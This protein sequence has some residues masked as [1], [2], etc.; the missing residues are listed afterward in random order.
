MWKFKD[1]QYKPILTA[2]KIFD[3][4]PKFNFTDPFFHLVKRINEMA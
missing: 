2:L 4:N 3:Q 1:N